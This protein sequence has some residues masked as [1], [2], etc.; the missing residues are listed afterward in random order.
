MCNIS[1]NVVLSVSLL[2]DSS[3][4]LRPSNGAGVGHNRAPWLEFCNWEFV[5]FCLTLISGYIMGE[6]AITSELYT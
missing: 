4:R 6:R 5:I 3:S 2:E 1:A